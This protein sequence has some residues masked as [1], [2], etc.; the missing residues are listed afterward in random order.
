MK[1]KHSNGILKGKI[2]KRYQVQRE[3]CGYATPQ[4]VARFC[5][6]WIGCAPSKAEA[7]A[8]AQKHAKERMQ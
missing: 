1:V 7:W 8:L 5:E 4:H 6:Q 2:D 3:H